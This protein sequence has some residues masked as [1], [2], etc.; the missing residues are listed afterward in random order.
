MSP[1]DGIF[2]RAWFAPL[3]MRG[4]SNSLTWHYLQA[5]AR[6]L[7][8]Q[9]CCVTPFPGKLLEELSESGPAL[10]QAPCLRG[11]CG[12]ALLVTAVS[13]PSIPPSLEQQLDPPQKE[14]LTAALAE[15]D[16]QL[17]KLADT[18]WLCQ[19]VEPGDEEVC[20]SRAPAWRPRTR[21]C[22]FCARVPL[23]LWGEDG[24]G[25]AAPDLAP[26][27]HASLLKCLQ[28][29]ETTWAGRKELGIAVENDP[30]GLGHKLPS[31]TELW[32]GPGGR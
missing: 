3:L 15:M 18:P 25:P 32:D 4:E 24:V 27:K 26:G 31:D 20:G 22:P 30:Q 11:P 28:G 23:W 6:S 12:P 14:R 1:A 19:P 2:R 9:G 29:V 16:Q 10:G 21:G 7:A 5:E 17:R 13:P 8:L